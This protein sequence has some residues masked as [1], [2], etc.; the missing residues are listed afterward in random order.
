MTLSLDKGTPLLSDPTTLASN[1]LILAVYTQSTAGMNIF[2][3]G[4][5]TSSTATNPSFTPSA[6]TIGSNSTATFSGRINEIIIYSNVLPTIQRQQVETYL[7]TKWNIT[8][9]YS[10]ALLSNTT[11][12]PTVNV[13][14]QTVPSGNPGTSTL[15]YEGRN[16][17]VH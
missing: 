13:G 1:T 15:Y 9:S 17:S 5:A 12:Q 14:Y 8:L 11:Y 2:I 7:A 16:W 6:T 3:N 10:N 4:T